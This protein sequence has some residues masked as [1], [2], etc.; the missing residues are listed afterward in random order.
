MPSGAA[1]CHR[2]L[3]AAVAPLMSDIGGGFVR[4]LPN[5]AGHGSPGRLRW[6]IALSPAFVR[7]RRYQDH[8]RFAT[9]HTAP[10]VATS[11]V[12]RVAARDPDT[13][14]PSDVCLFTCTPLSLVISVTLSARSTAPVP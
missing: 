2:R 1:C 8:G 11:P 12:R 10:G 13:K 14:R 7:R 4:L 5:R 3:S 6:V 9:E